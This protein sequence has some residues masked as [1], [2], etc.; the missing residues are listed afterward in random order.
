MLKV[1]FLGNCQAQAMESWVMQADGQ[2]EVT[3]FPAVW[4]IEEADVGEIIDRIESCDVLFAQ[5]LSDNFNRPEL[6]TSRLKDRF[7]SK[8]ISWPNVYFDGYFPGISYRYHPGGRILG[9][10]DEYHWDVIEANFQAGRSVADCVEEMET[11]AIL[12]R[13]DNPVA[14][15]LIQL[16]NREAG[17]D[18]VISDYVASNLHASRLFYSMNHPVNSLLRELLDRLFGE[19]GERKRLAVLSEYGFPL[20][21]IVLPVLP[22]IAARHGIDFS[23]DEKIKGVAV[24]FGEGDYTVTA[25]SQFY[26]MTE[27]VDCFYRTYECNK[28]VYGNG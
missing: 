16:G 25:T 1:G 24:K 28:S 5:R 14:D 11:D 7:G 12:A 10:L 26:T 8:L 18:V 3:T 4:L 20:N 15:S 23:R 19:I 2:L 13:S 21:K 27:L 17:L 6:A 22:A 9:P